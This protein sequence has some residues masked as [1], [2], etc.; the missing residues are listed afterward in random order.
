MLTDVRTWT[1]LAY[2]VIMLPLG[3]VY[4]TIA[5]TGLAVSVALIATPLTLFGEHFGMIDWSLNDHIYWHAGQP[6]TLF[7]PV[8]DGALLLVIGVLLLTALLHL[9]RRLI[10]MHARVAKAMLVESRA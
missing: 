4:F 9:A 7:H 10:R 1:T 5:V 3:I 8:I 2:L 6:W